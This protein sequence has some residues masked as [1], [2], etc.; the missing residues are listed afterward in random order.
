MSLYIQVLFVN[1]EKNVIIDDVI[2]YQSPATTEVDF[3]NVLS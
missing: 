2:Y 1:I 3:K